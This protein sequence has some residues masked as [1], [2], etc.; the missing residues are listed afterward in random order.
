M[1]AAAEQ[2]LSQ[3]IDTAIRKNLADCFVIVATF[4]GAKKS[5]PWLCHND[6]SEANSIGTPG[7][8]GRDFYFRA[9]LYEER[10]DRELA[11]ADY[12][13]AVRLGPNFVDS[14]L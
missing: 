9:W 8:T 1:D 2:Y 14:Y 7:V 3:A 6:Y 4:G 5:R 13:A 11:L 10:G 12:D